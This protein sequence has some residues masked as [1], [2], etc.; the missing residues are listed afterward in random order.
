MGI[1]IER[2]FL[3][4]DES[5]K[6]NVGEGLVCRQGYL[7]SGEGT[8]VRVRVLGNQGFL[9]IKG[10]TTNI[11]RTEFEYE[12]P[13][14]D[15]ESM[16]AMCGNLVEKTRYFI[17]HAG[18]QWELDVFVGENAG[19]VLAEIELESESQTIEIPEWAGQ[20]VS[21]DVRYYNAYLARHPFNQW[22]QVV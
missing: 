5:W 11:T 9:T 16:L 17:M 21:G 19:L 10:G 1:E 13:V 8:T 15:A 2:K 22:N 6:S 20:E 18:W 12:I 7:L 14:A 4:K 3:V